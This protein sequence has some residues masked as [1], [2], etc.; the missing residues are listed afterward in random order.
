MTFGLA[1]GQ[2]F[3]FFF[4]M[5]SCSNRPLVLFCYET[6]ACYLRQLVLD[7]FNRIGFKEN[8]EIVEAERYLDV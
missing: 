4:F 6:E 8:I 7:Y 3:F 5:M 1:K 2:T